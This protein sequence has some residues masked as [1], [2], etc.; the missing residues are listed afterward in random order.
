MTRQEMEAD[1]LEVASTG[2]SLAGIATAVDDDGNVPTLNSSLREGL[3]AAG[4]RPL[5]RTVTD[6]DFANLTDDELD[7]VQDVATLYILDLVIV[8][9]NRITVSD[10]GSSQQWGELYKGFTSRAEA[11]R[12]KIESLYGTSYNELSFGSISLNTIERCDRHRD[13]CYGHR[14]H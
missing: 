14:E 4:H 8:R 7:Q 2:M 1:I 12:A 11:L 9:W 13:D 5:S 3:I 6:D 10:N